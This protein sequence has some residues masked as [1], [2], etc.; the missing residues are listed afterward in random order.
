MGTTTKKK[1]KSR[2]H[3]FLNPYADMAFTR[4]PKCEQKTKQKKLP[5]LVGVEPGHVLTIINKTCRYCPFCDLLIIHQRKLEPLLALALGRPEAEVA[6]DNYV[7]LGT[8]DRAD[9]RAST[10]G[11]FSHADAHD[12]VYFFKNRWDFKVTGG[13][14]R[15]DDHE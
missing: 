2:H 8:L 6:S 14:S 10:R 1:S 4:C 3:F 11:Q 9:W 7:L 13:W 5:L 15:A 12:R